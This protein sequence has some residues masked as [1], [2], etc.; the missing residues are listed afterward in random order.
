MAGEDRTNDVSR[1]GRGTG[2]GT[3]PFDIE[4]AVGGMI[5]DQ[6]QGG[7]TIMI[8][9]RA[10]EIAM[11]DIIGKSCGQRAYRLLGGRCHRR[12]PAHAN[13]GYGAARTPDLQ[14]VQIIFNM[15]RLKTA[16]E[17]FAVAKGRKV[18]VIARVMVL[19]KI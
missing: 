4:E 5:R 14:S 8:A 15:F 6:Y 9:I 3:R 19:R 10:V 11:W 18:G 16:T 1:M 17:L 13:A 2:A 7:P 12:I